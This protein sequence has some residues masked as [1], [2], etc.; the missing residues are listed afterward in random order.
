MPI[1]QTLTNPLQCDANT[2]ESLLAVLCVRGLLTR[3]QTK[4]IAT[5]CAP[6]LPCEVAI[7]QRMP[8]GTTYISIDGAPAYEIN[9][10]S[11]LTYVGENT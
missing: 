3:N 11:K 7:S 1:K 8:K 10:R 6:H 2:L 5:A 4:A 9:N